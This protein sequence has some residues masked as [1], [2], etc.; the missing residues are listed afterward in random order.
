VSWLFTYENAKSAME[1]I[2]QTPYEIRNNITIKDKKIAIDEE[3]FKVVHVHKSNGEIG[4]VFIIKYSKRK[5]LW[6]NW[7]PSG[8]QQKILPKAIEHL[9]DVDKVNEEVWIQKR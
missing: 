3:D 5:D 1:S 9:V 8:N 4:I 7:Y 6:L 2:P